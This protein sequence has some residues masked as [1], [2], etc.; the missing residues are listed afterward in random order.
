MQM[1]TDEKRAKER[2]ALATFSFFFR[3]LS[4]L[5]CVHLWLMPSG[6][7]RGSSASPGLSFAA[8]RADGPFHDLG[9]E[10]EGAAGDDALAGLDAPDDLDDV[11]AV[12][13]PGDDALGAVAA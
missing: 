6:F 10:Q 11:A 5:I 9:L 7:Q 3:S 4:V 13:G 12:G 1:N 8:P 2:W